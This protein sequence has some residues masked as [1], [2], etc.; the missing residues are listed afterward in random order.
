[1]YL[2]SN[3]LTIL[4]NGKLQKG[5][6]TVAIAQSLSKRIN[7]Q[8]IA[9]ITVSRNLFCIMMHKL[10]IEPEDIVNQSDPYY[11]KEL[12]G[13][14]YRVSEWYNI[15][16]HHPELLIN[17][18]VLYHNKGLVCHTPTDILKIKP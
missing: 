10:N 11:K 5:K 4:Y 16:K 2:N 15:I 9:S 14:E 7:K 17:P 18:V 6:Q 13:K 8:D 3:D 1:M 12:Q